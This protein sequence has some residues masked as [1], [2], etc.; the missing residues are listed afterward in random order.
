MWP[1]L[2]DWW[3]QAP[4][5]TPASW[6]AR[7]VW[8]GSRGGCEGGSARLQ[9]E[10]QCGEG[11]EPWVWLPSAPHAPH[12]ET[13]SSWSACGL[14]GMGLGQARGIKAA[15]VA[16][17]VTLGAPGPPGSPGALSWTS[18]LHFLHF[19]NYNYKS[20]SQNFRSEPGPASIDFLRLASL[21]VP[22]LDDE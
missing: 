10:E 18:F 15:L 3:L 16:A 8:S 22:P 12:T 21:L 6:T 20:R 9:E 17:T 7:C 1:F 19:L 4:V 14:G 13:L 5:L 2:W 11:W